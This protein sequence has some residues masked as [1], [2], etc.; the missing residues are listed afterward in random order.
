MYSLLPEKWEIT[1]NQNVIFQNHLQVKWCTRHVFSCN[2]DFSLA[3]K[4]I[5]ENPELKNINRKRFSLN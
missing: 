1:D 3:E 2:D 5:N 4:M